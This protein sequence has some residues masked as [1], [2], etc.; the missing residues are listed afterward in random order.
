[1]LLLLLLLAQVKSINSCKSFEPLSALPPLQQWLGVLA[2]E[3]AERMAED[4]AEHGRRARSL[5]ERGDGARVCAWLY[6]C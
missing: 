3:L 5:G 1:L 4:E 2:A 6:A